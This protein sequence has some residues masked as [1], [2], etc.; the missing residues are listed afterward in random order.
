MA[1]RCAKISFFLYYTDTVTRTKFLRL[2]PAYSIVTINL[3]SE[4]RKRLGV[5]N[6]RG[7]IHLLDLHLSQQGECPNLQ[8]ST[9]ITS[10]ALSLKRKL[11]PFNVNLCL[12]VTYLYRM[13]QKGFCTGGRGNNCPRRHF[14]N[15]NDG[16]VL[17]VKCQ[18]RN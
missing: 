16:P 11:H 15:E 3:V 7:N 12:L 14:Y 17:E 18:I 8:V 2:L 6:V 13:W 4:K 9:I 1:N 10:Q 5:H